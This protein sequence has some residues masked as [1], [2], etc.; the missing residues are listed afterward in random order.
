MLEQLVKDLV[1]QSRCPA[2]VA[3]ALADLGISPRYAAWS[4][5]AACEALGINPRIAEL[6]L[7]MLVPSAA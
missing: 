2:A 1:M 6:R 4:L 7:S 5:R 3:L